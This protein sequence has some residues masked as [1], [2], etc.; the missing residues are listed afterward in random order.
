LS[1][2]GRTGTIYDAPPAFVS[3]F[4][5]GAGDLSE[6]LGGGFQAAHA[7]INNPTNQ[8]LW[9]EDANDIVPPGAMGRVVAL[10]NTDVGKASWTIPPIFGIK[11]A[12]VDRPSAA[13][14]VWLNAGVDISP[15]QG[16]ATRLTTV[17]NALINPG[18]IVTKASASGQAVV[19]VPTT[20]IFQPGGIVNL[21]TQGGAGISQLALV[22]S[23]DGAAGTITIN[24]N[25]V[26]PLAIGDIVQVV[27]VV[28][29]SNRKRAWDFTSGQAAGI[30]VGFQLIVAGIA[31]QRHIVNHISVVMLQISGAASGVTITCRDGSSAGFIMWQ[32]FT[33]VTVTVGDKDRIQE[34]DLALPASVGNAVYTQM[35][36]APA[37]LQGSVSIGGY[38]SIAEPT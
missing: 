37:G 10:R 32:T 1:Q 21:L 27:P 28:L 33:G 24:T 25:L 18:V 20:T 8:Y 12:P 13:T 9:L 4:K 19:S 17:D 36:T 2:F 34:G 22:K 30:G 29:A 5:T 38:N 15:Q 14:I 11:Q 16:V 35:E 23:V 26:N 6:Q 3:I 7:W 31:G